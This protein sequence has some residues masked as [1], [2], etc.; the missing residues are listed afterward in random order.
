MLMCT[1]KKT[2]MKNLN[3]SFRE[4]AGFLYSTKIQYATAELLALPR[5]GIK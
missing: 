5:D 2:D 4:L 3:P 1:I